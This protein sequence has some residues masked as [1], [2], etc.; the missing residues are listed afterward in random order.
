[1]SF[2]PADGVG[3]G[4]GVAFAAAEELPPNKLRPKAK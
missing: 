1:M 2:L 3:F 4:V